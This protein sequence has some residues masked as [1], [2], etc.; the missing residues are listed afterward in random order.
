MILN[1]TFICIYG[2]EGLVTQSCPTLW[3]PKDYSP[4]GSPVHGI[5]QAGI[6]EWVAISFSIC[7]YKRTYLFL[8]YLR[9]V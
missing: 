3:D 8:V 5:S 4:P 2:G 7:I 1:T 9:K 6:F